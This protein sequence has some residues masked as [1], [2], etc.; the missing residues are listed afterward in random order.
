MLTR[1]LT[2]AAA[3]AALWLA[4]GCR[5]SVTPGEAKPYE[6]AAR[7]IQAGGT[8]YKISDPAR[9]FAS[10]EQLF[11]GLE[12]SLASPDNQLP[13]E[14]VR[15]LQQFSAAFALAWR[16]A[17]VDEL[18]ASGASSV[19]LAGEQGLFENR[20]FLALPPEPRGF[21]WKLTGGG[22]RPLRDEFGA[23]PVNTVFAADLTVEP[24]A[25]GRALKQLEMTSRLGDELV[26][27]IF[28]T[29]L[30][31][32]LAGV[33]GEWSILV[34]AAGDVSA[35]ALDGVRV[36]ITLPDAGGRFFRCLAGVAQLVPGTVS[37]ENRIVF[38]P[39]NN[40][41]VNWRP[42]LHYDDGRLY[43]Y[44][45]REMLD[46]LADESAPRLADTPEFHRLA[47]GLPESGSGFV[48][49]GGGMALFR[50]ELASLLGAEAAAALAELDRTEL[51]VFR[52]ETDGKLVV[53]HGSWD[54]NQAEF[55]ERALIPAAG[56]MAL[57]SP[58]FNE[59]RRMLDEQAVREKCRLQLRA[60]AE[61][62]EKYAAEHHG[63]FPEKEGI[64]GLKALLKTGLI[65]P[66]MLICPGAEDEAAA[67]AGS[68][69]FDNCSYLYFGGFS[70]KSN[71]KLP[72][73]IDWPFN[74]A[75]AVNV[76]L[77]DGSVETL[78][79]ENPENC[80]RVVSYLHTRY[81]YTEPEFK[82]LMQKA[83]ALDQQFELD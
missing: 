8:Y 46:C 44:S 60:L 57:V 62:L 72:L 79:L 43:F 20:M 9:L 13:P 69:T 39:L 30:E 71:P 7:H 68:F 54:L 59:H 1:I 27:P 56:L 3:A 2:V 45:S 61:A 75:D 73:V 36:L 35:D 34:T 64:A 74:H 6:Q 40:F 22:N 42:E 82:Q 50:D 16:L 67:D 66:S 28:N 53:S 11:H 76:I 78:E 52:N 58:Y 23:L 38:G 77:A 80:R 51:T 81:H 4:G 10:L 19:P 26:E 55:A 17:G 12:L 25:L 83:A 49:S 70:R 63:S 21:L 33:S 15:E 37:E 41:G 5:S 31:P 14:F 47:A 18:A 29:P 32:L 65:A 24:I 48:Y